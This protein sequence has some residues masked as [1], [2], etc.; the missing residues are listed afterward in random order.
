ME[1]PGKKREKL[2]T[3]SKLRFRGWNTNHPHIHLLSNGQPATN[4]RQRKSRNCYHS[5]AFGLLLP[6]LF[7]V[8]V[9]CCC[10][11]DPWGHHGRDNKNGSDNKLKAIRIIIL[12][13]RYGRGTT[14][15]KPA[16]HHGWIYAY[17]WARKAPLIDVL[18]YFDARATSLP[19]W[20]CH[21]YC[22]PCS[23]G[24]PHPPPRRSHNQPPMRTHNNSHKHS[25]IVSLSEPPPFQPSVKSPGG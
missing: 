4:K 5:L 22:L 15:R 10:R 25:F 12:S 6:C 8:T 23:P 16:S 9:L 18:S 14:T 2:F 1:F 17:L 19:A 7:T 13:P 20:P 21:R 24:P 11:C 3:F